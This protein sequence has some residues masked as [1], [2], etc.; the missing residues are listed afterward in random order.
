MASVEELQEQIELQPKIVEGL[1]E[2]NK[3]LDRQVLHLR[4]LEE[5]EHEIRLQE[6]Q[7]L[8]KL[9]AVGDEYDQVSKQQRIMQVLMLCR[10]SRPSTGTRRRRSRGRAGCSRRT[11]PTWEY[12]FLSQSNIQKTLQL[13]KLGDESDATHVFFN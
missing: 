7:E 9:Q 8:K 6:E 1:K 13:L 11:S 4:Q 5:V 3:R 12:L 2:V 10:N